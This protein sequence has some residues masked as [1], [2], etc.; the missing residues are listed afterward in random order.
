MADE[1][2]RVAVNISACGTSCPNMFSNRFQSNGEK[3]ALGLAS[4]G[5][6]LSHG[7]QN[8]RKQA[9]S[10]VGTTSNSNV[11]TPNWIRRR[12]C[13][14][15]QESVVLIQTSDGCISSRLFPWAE[16]SRGWPFGL[17]N[18]FEFLAQGSGLHLGLGVFSD[19]NPV[20]Q[21]ALRMVATTSGTSSS[22]AMGRAAGTTSHQQNLYYN[23]VACLWQF[24]P[25]W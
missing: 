14:V 3:N 24:A 16:T 11:R 18:L 7:S 22:V 13:S 2:V 6:G 8:L 25:C 9:R 20:V 21:L 5:P 4:A 1:R 15:E 19:R 12:C 10:A 17:G 23:R